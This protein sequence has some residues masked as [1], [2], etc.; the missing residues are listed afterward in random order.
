MQTIEFL[1]EGEYIELLKLLKAVNIAQTG[2]H[3][4]MIVD[5]E[6]V[7][8]NGEVETRRRAKIIKGDVLVIDEEIEITIV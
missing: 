4:K 7:V 1:L 5:D 2:G 3:A 6:L 8:R